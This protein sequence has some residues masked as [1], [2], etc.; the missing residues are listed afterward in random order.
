MFKSD[1]PLTLSHS[2]LVHKAVE[3]KALLKSKILIVFLARN[4]A[5]ISILLRNVLVS[6]FSHIKLFLM[7]N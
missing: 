4:F 6:V 7:Q 5:N 1:S 2:L 3:I